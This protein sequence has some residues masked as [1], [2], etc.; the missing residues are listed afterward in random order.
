MVILR[1]ILSRLNVKQM[2]FRQGA[3]VTGYDISQ[4]ITRQWFTVSSFMLP[5]IRLCPVRYR[6]VE[7]KEL[8][9]FESLFKALLGSH[10]WVTA[11]SNTHQSYRRAVLLTCRIGRL[12]PSSSESQK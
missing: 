10:L 2:S 12:S 3:G 8:Q 7:V 4:Q 5:E 1:G 6:Q 11:E 9:L